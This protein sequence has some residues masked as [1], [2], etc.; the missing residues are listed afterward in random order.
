MSSIIVK[1]KVKGT[2]KTPPD[3]G[4]GAGVLA[5]KEV[6][7]KKPARKR[8]DKL[9]LAITLNN[10]YQSLLE[11]NIECVYEKK[12]ATKKKKV[13]NKSNEQVLTDL[14]D[15]HFGQDKAAV[16]HNIRLI[17]TEYAKHLMNDH[18]KR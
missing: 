13:L 6:V 1:L 8:S 9:S 2:K 10:V 4:L 14:I 12:S 11:D 18:G 15:L 17:A 3:W 5:T 16:R 7:L